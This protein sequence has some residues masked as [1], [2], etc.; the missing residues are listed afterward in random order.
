M[1]LR[2]NKKNKKQKY[3]EINRILEDILKLLNLY[4]K[5]LEGSINSKDNNKLKR[6][7]QKI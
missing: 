4:K 2:E 1:K 7:I 3:N 6:I 5:K